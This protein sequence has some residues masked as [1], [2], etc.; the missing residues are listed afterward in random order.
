MCIR[1]SANTHK[2]TVTACLIRLG[3]S[4]VL[5]SARFGCNTRKSTSAY[6]TI[7]I[8]WVFVWIGESNESHIFYVLFK[9]VA[10]ITLSITVTIVLFMP[11]WECLKLYFN[12]EKATN[13]AKTV[14]FL[15]RVSQ[16]D[17]PPSLSHWLE[18][19]VRYPRTTVVDTL[20]VR[21]RGS[22][23]PESEQDLSRALVLWSGS[24]RVVSFPW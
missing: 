2:H 9:F 7:E 12:R 15:Y 21:S 5:R 4:C 13:K 3:F 19:F 14:L 10:W 6:Q 16:T 8:L 24:K 1:D 20:A 22:A 11:V 23:V 17:L 18:I